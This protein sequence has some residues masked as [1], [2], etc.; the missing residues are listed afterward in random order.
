MS[1]LKMFLEHLL[2]D[3]YFA[4]SLGILKITAAKKL[5]ILVN[6]NLTLRETGVQM[7]AI[8]M[9]MLQ[10]TEKSR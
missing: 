7:N 8:N 6:R 10:K 3:H 1:N 9:T 5:V 2:S 4:E